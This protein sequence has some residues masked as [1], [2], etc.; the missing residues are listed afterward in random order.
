MIKVSGLTKRYGEHRALHQVSFHIKKGEVVGLLGPNGAGKS[1]LLN[2]L[3]GYIFANEGQ[4]LVDGMD[5]MQSLIAV[6]RKI[7]FLPEKPPLYKDMTVKEYLLFVAELNGIAKKDRHQ[8]MEKAAHHTSITHVIKRRIKNL[9]KGYCQRVGLSQALIGD[10]EILL[11]DEP[12]VGLDPKQI[13]DMRQLIQELSTTRTII[14]SSHILSEISVLCDSIL[15]LN[16][17]HMIAHEKVED[18]IKNALNIHQLTLRLGQAG[19]DQETI[20]ANIK[21]MEGVLDTYLVGTYE[22]NTWDY[23]ISV[24]KG[25]DIRTQLVALCHEK[26]YPLLMLQ[27]TVLTLE[28]MFMKLT[29]EGGA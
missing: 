1:T 7:G 16:K 14:I 3:T 9:S 27:P 24:N 13:M 6:K 26:N 8:A 19:C 12:T 10:K 21:C 2:I 29:E 11:L 4:V 17:G 20:I 28:E 18:M 5:M 23:S 22:P 15:L 25:Y